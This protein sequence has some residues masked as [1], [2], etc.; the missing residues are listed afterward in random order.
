MSSLWHQLY[1]CGSRREWWSACPRVP[2]TTRAAFLH[3]LRADVRFL[4][5]LHGKV[6]P[7]HPHPA[8]THTHLHAHKHTDTPLTHSPAPMSCWYWWKCSGCKVC[9]FLTPTTGW[10]NPPPNNAPH[11]TPPSFFLIWPSFMVWMVPPLHKKS[12]CIKNN[13]LEF[14]N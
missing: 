3:Q 12:Q 13:L 7:P 9:S 14:F 5:R 11:S 2:L 10:I 1:H 6:H 4:A 8:H